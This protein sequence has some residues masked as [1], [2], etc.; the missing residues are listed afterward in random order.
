MAVS[1]ETHEVQGTPVAE[2]D[3]GDSKRVY[4]HT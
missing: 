4:M 2:L 3:E 1:R